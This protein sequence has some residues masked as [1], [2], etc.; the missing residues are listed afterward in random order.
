LIPAPPAPRRLPFLLLLATALACGIAA[1]HAAAQG[2]GPAGRVVDRE[3]RGPL[4]AAR[5]R[6]SAE[7]THDS[8]ATVTDAEGRWSLSLPRGRGPFELRAERIGYLPLTLTLDGEADA[9]E[10][11]D[12]ALSP[13][14]V[15]LAGVV[16]QAGPPERQKRGLRTP[17]GT[18]ETT[19]SWTRGPMPVEPG[20]LAALAGLTAGVQVADDGTGISMFGQ[21]PSQTRTTLDGAS[22]GATTLPAEALA[23]VTVVTSAY[24]ASRGQYSAGAVEASTMSGTNLFGGAVRSRFSSPGL[25]WGVRPGLDRWGEQ[26]LGYG[27]GAAGGA[28]VRNRWF[29]YGAF[30][31]SRRATPLLSLETAGP[32]VLTGMG[33]S[34]DSAARLQSLLRAGGIGAAEREADAVTGR[35]SALLRL[36]YDFSPRN[37]L[38]LRLDGAAASLERLGVDPLSTMASGGGLHRAAGGVL[39]QLTTRLPQ[40]GNELRVYRA[41][42]TQRLEPDC[43]GPAGVVRVT[44]A[45]GDGWGSSTLRFGGSALQSRAGGELLEVADELTAAAR[46]GHQLRAGATLS[47]GRASYLAAA[48]R[49]GTFAFAG[50]AELAAGQPAAFTRTLGGDGRAGVA[51]TR[52][53]ALYLGDTWQRGRLALTYGARLE[54]R[55]YPAD[56]PAPPEVAGGLRPGRIP[57]EWGVS[58]RLG[59]TYDGGRW[60]LKGGVGEFR[61]TVLPQ[62]LAAAAGQTG[63]DGEVV[64]TCV[65]PAAPAA[66]WALYAG[67]PERIPAAC[68]DGADVFASRAA[69]ATV[70]APGFAAPRAWH[71]SVGGIRYLTPRTRLQLDASLTRGVKQGLA[72]DRNLASPAFT[73]AGEGGRPVYA[74]AAAIDPRMGGAAP[75]AS[76]LFPGWGA[77]REIGAGG[78]STA[79]QA[80][81]SLEAYYPRL[82][83]IVRASYAWTRVRDQVGALPALDGSLP[84]AS[85]DGGPADGPGDRERTHDLQFRLTLGPRPWLRVGVLGRLTSGAPFTPRVDGDVNGDGAANDPAFVFDPATTGDTALAGGMSRLL[86]SLPGAVRRCLEREMG[87]VAGRNVCRSAAVPSLDLRMEMQPWRRALERRLLLSVTTSN[88]LTLLDRALHGGDGLRGWGQPGAADPTLLRVRGFDP[89]ARAFRYEVNPGFGTRAGERLPLARPFAL[90]LEARMAVGA[91]PAQ[92]PLQALVRQTAGAGRPAEEV[93]GELERRIPNLAAQVLALDSS[94]ALALS[95]AQRGALLRQARGFGERVAPAADSLAAAV[96]RAEAGGRRAKAEWRGV[97]QLTG[98]IQREIGQELGRVHELLSPDQWQKLPEAVRMPSRQLIGPRRLGGGRATEGD[99]G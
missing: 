59:W 95:D 3:Q 12:L 72:F 53:G 79:L 20:D 87:R 13:S 27:E 29:W 81:G 45:L 31:V 5:V 17:G 39:A 98:R 69:A 14:P 34:P 56:G 50:L 26:T 62:A 75:A 57:G 33:V 23:N 61:G 71:A 28:V 2:N 74:P 84:L 42:E 10:W 66:D 44:S 8:L 18:E 36:D 1:P 37:S 11:R 41:S 93:R 86:A 19:L 92:Q 35:G 48:N 6:I 85:P 94:A 4:A 22:F 65:G 76:R 15:A 67:S 55:R 51:R 63:D 25:Q 49:F 99:G 38:M 16:A 77:V 43:S 68:A 64:L 78:T 24:D 73:L 82:G 7:D 88:A 52:Y 47:A 40:L 54:A 60:N 30:G 9:A 58:P 97:Q 70:F 21:D 46:G 96:S 83:L 32:A 90:I 91:D 89:A 80:S